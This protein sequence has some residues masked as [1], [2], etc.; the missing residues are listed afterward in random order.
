M[1]SCLW[2]SNYGMISLNYW[3]SVRRQNLI[4]D[5]KQLA[6]WTD[7][8]RRSYA[9]AAE[10]ELKGGGVTVTMGR[11]NERRWCK[12]DWKQRHI[13]KKY[14]YFIHNHAKFHL[15]FFTKTSFS[16]HFLK[17][18]NKITPKY[19]VKYWP[20]NFHTKNMPRTPLILPQ[21]PGGTTFRRGTLNEK[22][23]AIF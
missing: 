15:T 18:V 11:G 22:E 9:N 5:V 10:W 23:V 1:C 19:Q 12:H 14:S 3:S 6:K 20:S 2:N 16:K 13:F 21:A 17:L 8:F 7:S 4:D